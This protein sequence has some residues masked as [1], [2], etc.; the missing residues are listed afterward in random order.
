MPA[1][2]LD[3]ATPPSP[4]GFLYFSEESDT[5]NP[6]TC[7]LDDSKLRRSNTMNE[8]PSNPTEA[9]VGLFA[10]NQYEIH[11]FI[12]TLVPNWADAD[13]VMQA[14]SDRHRV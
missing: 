3:E 6:V 2:L 11:S 10:Q 14:T 4:G 1:K 12:L 5:R 13:D 8:N 9:F 7:T